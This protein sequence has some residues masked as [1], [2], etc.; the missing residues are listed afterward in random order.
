LPVTGTG[1]TVGKGGR[2]GVSEW[3]LKSADPKNPIKMYD[4]AEMWRVYKD[5]TTEL[6]ATC[7]KGKFIKMK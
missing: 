4:G 7:V 6:I 5:G 3:M 2:L 1:F